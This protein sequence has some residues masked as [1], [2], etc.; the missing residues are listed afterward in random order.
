MNKVYSTRIA[1]ARKALHL[2]QTELGRRI[3]VTKQT[4]SNYE[5]G[6]REP[7][8]ETLDA[9]TN[10]LN[11]NL[12]YLVGSTDDMSPS[13]HILYA[14]D[15]GAHYSDGSVSPFTPPEDDDYAPD[16]PRPAA[17]LVAKKD[18]PRTAL[19]GPILNAKVTVNPDVARAMRLYEALPTE[20]RKAILNMMEVMTEANG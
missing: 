7:D 18:D 13:P 10:A 5:T 15:E 3:G 14:D 8:F 9:L 6:T 1:N 2:S 17:V 11:V 19:L 12:G 4:I 20:K 16:E